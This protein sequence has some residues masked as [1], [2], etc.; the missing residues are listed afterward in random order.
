MKTMKRNILVGSMAFISLASC[1]YSANAAPVQHITYRSACEAGEGRVTKSNSS[2][3][4]DY[5]TLEEAQ[6]A[7]LNDTYDPDDGTCNGPHT[8]SPS[9]GHRD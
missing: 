4:N 2:G 5:A 3:I 9:C 8:Y 1:L 7:C 6:K